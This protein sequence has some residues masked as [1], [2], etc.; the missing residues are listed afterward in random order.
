MQTMRVGVPAANQAT[1]AAV[2]GG[3]ESEFNGNDVP[4]QGGTGIVNVTGAASKWLVGGTLQIGGFNLGSNGAGGGIDFEGDD[5][6]YNSEAGRGTLNVLD[7]ALVDISTGSIPTGGGSGQI[8]YLANGRFGRIKL[9]TGG[10]INIGGGTLNEPRSRDMVFFNDGVIEGSGRIQTGVF[11]NRYLGEVRVGA[12][13]KLVIDAEADYP[14]P[15][16][17][18]G[19]NPAIP[20]SPIS[21]LVNYGVIQVFGTS[22]S[23]AELEFDR[24]PNE[25]GL[26]PIQ[27]MR[28]ERVVRPTGVPLAD[29]YGGLISAQHSILRFRSGLINTGMM[30]F[31]AGNNYVTGNV[32]NADVPMSVD[33]GIITITGPGTKVTFENDLLA[34]GG[35]IT[36]GP[37]ATLEVLARHSFL[38]AGDLKVTLHPTQTSHIFAAGDAGI[39]GKLSINL[40][41][42]APGSLQIGDTFEIISVSGNMGG[43]DLSDPNNPKIDLLQAP[44]FSLVSFPNLASLGLPA[45][46]IL[47]P[48]YTAHSVLISVG[49]AAGAIGPDFNGDGVVNGLDLNIWLANVGTTAGASVVQGDADSDGDVDGDDFLFWQRNVGKPMPWAGAGSG[50]G[51]GLE[52]SVPEPTSL[53][54]LLISVVCSLAIRGRR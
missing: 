26:N 18:P 5:I 48:V 9:G 35:G 51:S 49:S 19:G 12:G 31:S 6:E 23:K 30:S 22:D 39:A 47:Q 1:V 3:G 38:T 20:G 41:G 53:V 13:E 33:D 4:E 40:S 42:F 7:G 2:I 34:P 52:G 36:V 10:L 50:S 17:P 37:G 14:S 27:P 24:A 8:L 28:N 29:F 25:Q 45:T 15:A 46:T 44:L 32:L 11:D 16:P 54:L 21:P 43:V